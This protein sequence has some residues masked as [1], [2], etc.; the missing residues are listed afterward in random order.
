M[1]SI[2]FWRTK[3]DADFCIF[4][5]CLLL[6]PP[7]SF[8]C[9]GWYTHAADQLDDDGRTTTEEAQRRKRGGRGGRAAQRPNDT[10]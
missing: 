8:V 4:L 6:P 5:R 3:G 1:P 7:A 9:D 10:N 2:F